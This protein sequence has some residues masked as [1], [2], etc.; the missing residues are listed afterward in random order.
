MG[1][2]RPHT[3]AKPVAERSAAPAGLRPQFLLETLAAF[4]IGARFWGCQRG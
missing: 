2:E 4:A 3:T 1:S